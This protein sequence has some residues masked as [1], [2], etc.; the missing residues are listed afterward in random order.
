MIYTT[1]VR[2]DAFSFSLE[3]MSAVAP[4]IAPPIV[5]SDRL[6]KAMDARFNRGT[7]ADS[8]PAP[9]VGNPR[10]SWFRRIGGRVAWSTSSQ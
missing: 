2:H 1:K 4:V 9:G 6:S 3:G 10:M 7:G 8:A 5:A